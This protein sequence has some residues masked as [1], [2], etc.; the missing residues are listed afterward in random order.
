MAEI[1]A[2]FLDR[3]L[4]DRSSF[5]APPFIPRR[6]LK[7]LGTTTL[8]GE[9]YFS[10][11][12]MKKEWEHVWTKTWH[13]VMQAAELDQP[14][15]FYVHELGK[16]SFLFVRG[17]DD[18]IRGFYNVCRHRGNRLCQV[19]EG[20]MESFTC[21]YHGWKWNNDGTLKQVADPQFFR[22]FD[23]GIP[24]ED[25]GLVPVQVDIW[26]G[27]LW[28]NMDPEC[29]SLKEFL[30]PIGQHLETYHFADCTVLDFQTFE[31][32]ANWKHA[33]DAFN[34]SY[35]F[36]ELHPNMIQ[37]G[38]GHDIPIELYGI[39]SRMLNFNRTVS[40]VLEERSEWTELRRRFMLS[41]AALGPSPDPDAAQKSAIEIDGKPID[42]KDMHMYEIEYR[43]SIED[44]THLPFKEMNDEQLVHQYHYS[45][46]PGV[47]FTQSA[48]GGAIFRYRPHPTDP[49]RCFYDLFIFANLPPDMD[50][51]ERP[52]HQIHRYED[53][54]DYVK[55]LEN[56]FDPAY[57][58][59]VGEDASN[60]PTLQ[61]GCQ[62]DSFQG[63][64]L[65]DQEIRLR[66]FHQVLDGFIDGSI[67]TQ[68]LPSQD[69]FMEPD[70]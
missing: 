31:W 1:E 22:Q 18:Q 67:T 7:D 9:R 54:I 42:A 6:K 20:V 32:H 35:H 24:E 44:E 56:T 64:I 43:R 52:P 21:P 58:K 53:G 4:K 15:A 57:S 68:K 30:G 11:E 63:A 33:W 55:V 12:F 27:W 40:E 60:M 39:H 25:L 65:G 29:C 49:N 37:I 5:K 50:A 19:D 38:E 41:E 2:D 8:S 61:A 13:F 14:G 26:E 23:N 36:A 28:F 3:P 34:E 62:S 47:T 59:V 48:D 45:F 17:A 10:S 70:Q 51:P 66:H 16:E 46:F 69:A